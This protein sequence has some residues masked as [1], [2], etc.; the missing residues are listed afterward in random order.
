MWDELGISPCEDP[1]TIRRAYTARL[2]KLDPDR[3]PAA[4]ARLREALEQALAVAGDTAEP[5]R[6]RPSEADAADHAIDVGEAFD[7]T[8]Q[9]P[10]SGRAHDD[11]LAMQDAPVMSDRANAAPEWLGLTAPDR[12]LLDE[13][14]SA[15]ARRDAT[16]AIGHYYHAAATGA[17]A[18][19]AAP[20][21]L[22]RLFAL[23]L[24]E[25]MVERTVFRELARTSGWDKAVPEPG[26]TSEVRQ[27]ALAR[28]AAESWYDA[29]LA[30]A[31]RPRGTTRKQAKL[32][33][34]MLGRIGRNRMPRI[35]RA[36]L[37]TRLDEFR[38]HEA[39]LR[40]RID[41]GWAEKLEKRVLRREI[42][43]LAAIF[44][45]IAAMALN[46]L[47]L[48]VLEGIAGTLSFGAT[49]AAL[50]FAAVLLCFLMLPIMQLRLLL[51]PVSRPSAF[52]TPDDSGPSET[53]PPETE[54]PDDPEAR[55]RWL[56]Q[57]AE[58]AY[59]AMYD[60]PTDLSAAGS[61]SNAKEFLHDA[62]ALARRLG[63][64]ATAERLSERLTEIK[65]VYRSQSIS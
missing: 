65:A 17:V 6:P 20:P 31:E 4:F 24:E 45:L 60:A 12:A 27:R 49:A 10:T 44:L 2:K 55:L 5:P 48:V 35:D 7:P 38:N 50:F 51:R 22:D 52:E 41:P 13:L 32:A 16:A 34:L 18:L 56:E 46:G 15:L 47:R 19:H 36:A 29:L 21:L 26:T 64:S 53:E 3:D 8:L 59:E 57:Q 33:R 14:E 9:R 61:Y 23:S 54:P 63:D 42:A 28:L 25:P 11:V 37:K 43:V 30:A 1:K 40:D 58:F 39:W 62:I